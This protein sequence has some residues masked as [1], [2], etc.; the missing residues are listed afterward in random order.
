[1]FIL[2]FYLQISGSNVNLED[3]WF[4]EPEDKTSS[5]SSKKDENES[6]SAADLTTIPLE[7]VNE[8]ELIEKLQKQLSDRD[9]K[10][11]KTCIENALLNEKLSQLISENKELTSNID[12]LD[13][14]HNIAIDEI[15]RVKNDQVVRFDKLQ[16]D[17]D[18]LNAKMGEIIKERDVSCQEFEI[19]S[20]RVSMAQI[21]ILEKNEA[22]EKSYA[23]VMENELHLKGDL[24]ILKKEVESLIL[25][26]AELKTKLEEKDKKTHQKLEDILNENQ[27]SSEELKKISKENADLQEMVKQFEK[28]LK[29]KSDQSTQDQNANF[30]ERIKNLEDEITAV[31][32]ENSKFKDDY[33]SACQEKEEM[34]EE[35]CE[36][37]KALDEFTEKFEHDM[38]DLKEK[39]K[40]M[41]ELEQENSNLKQKIQDLELQQEY[42]PV[43][44][45]SD[46]LSFQ[47]MKSLIKKH[48]NFDSN[49]VNEKDYFD[50]FL[51][52]TKDITSKLKATEK[53]LM[54][55]GHELNVLKEAYQTLESEKEV[56]KTDLLNYEVECSEL[57]KNND[58]LVMEVET[59]KGG[60]LETIPEQ[61]EDIEILE[62]QLEDCSNLKQNLQDDYNQVRAS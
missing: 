15:M 19:D 46:H 13:K 32:I 9:Q 48:F 58:I 39:V 53:Q 10:L 50:D 35:L 17:Y 16:K 60:K 55:A 51:E 37:K 8:H 42:E 43:E 44:K 7:A 4:W 22:L 23:T 38:L 5:T 56:L 52:S 12:E 2:L 29:S 21:E 3:S 30:Y 41:E 24:D 54:D 20:Q 27:S 14:Q 40:Y 1:M 25:E 59:L 57:A 28:E 18:A 47:D 62:Q 6:P 34:F 45:M 31:C 61:N 36:R 33:E 11:K 49:L 26:N